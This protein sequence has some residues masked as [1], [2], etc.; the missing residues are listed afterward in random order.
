MKRRI[1][2]LALL[3]TFLLA[4][5]PALAADS[6]SAHTPLP[7]D[8]AQLDNLRL[9][10]QA[11][12]GAR[13]ETGERFSFNDAVGPRT[14]RRG[15]RTAPNGRGV[16]VT[17]GGVA[18]A[19]ST[20]YLALLKLGDG[21]AIEPVKTYGSRFTGRYVDDPAHALVTDYDAGID[22]AFTNRGEGLPIDMWLG[23]DALWCVVTAGEA[24][25]G[26]MGS[27][28]APGA[29]GGEGLF[30]DPAPNVTS[31]ARALLGSADLDCGGDGDVLHNVALAADCVNDTVLAGGDTFSFNDVVGPRTRKYGYRRAI[32]GRGVKVTGGGVAQV[33]AALWLAV[34]DM[35]DIAIVEKSTY[36][37]K[38]NQHYVASS[39]DAILTDYASGR[40]FSFRYTGP[41]SVTL[42][43][44]TRDGRLRVEI[45]KN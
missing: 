44:T 12:D 16:K 15:Y 32:N 21:V 10:V 17:G 31:P 34:K 1:V 13:V 39:A 6:H 43:A 29:Q 45:Y 27:A 19:A 33:A 7:D 2:A 23:D 42:Y 36:G 24:A 26:F 40:D 9:A 41:A 4:L 30:L 25:F 20:L 38:Y 37:G 35:D 28:D 5:P 22:L 8:A 11:L 3:L 18:Q 14:R